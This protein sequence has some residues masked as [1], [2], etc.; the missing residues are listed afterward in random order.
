MN[1]INLILL[2]YENSEWILLYPLLISCF[3]LINVF[4]CFKRKRYLLNKIVQKSF[5]VIII[6]LFGIIL[7]LVG[8][9][10]KINCIHFNVLFF[11]IAV[12]LIGMFFIFQ[13]IIYGK[14]ITIFSH[15]I[16]CLLYVFYSELFLLSNTLSLD[17]LVFLVLLFMIILLDVALFLLK[18]KGNKKGM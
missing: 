4:I 2:Y 5:S 11:L 18:Q 1:V 3:L 9:S 6:S 8:I 14:K 12:G 16:Q 10:L 7:N 15:L 13:L 17:C